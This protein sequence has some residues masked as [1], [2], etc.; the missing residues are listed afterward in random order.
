VPWRVQWDEDDRVAMVAAIWRPVGGWVRGVL[1]V[2]PVGGVRDQ[3][4]RKG[5]VPG[6]DEGN[7]VVDEGVFQV[8]ISTEATHWYYAHPVD[9]ACAAG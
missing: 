2:E 1:V 8:E 9:A 3:W 5:G 6:G 4:A 7:H